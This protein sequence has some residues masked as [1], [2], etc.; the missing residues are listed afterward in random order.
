[1]EATHIKPRPIEAAGVG[2]P[3]TQSLSDEFGWRDLEKKVA[4]VFHQLPPQDQARAAILAANYGEAAALDVFGGEDGL[5]PALSGQNQYWLWGPRGH[6]GSLIIHVG[7][8][9]ERWRRICG[10]IEPAGRFGNPYA[11]PYENDRAIFICRD[12]RMPLDRLWDRLKR[13][14]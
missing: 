6:D 10:S 14:R 2:A 1:M 11:M 5:P 4:A 13:F 12:L 8:D 3:L 9:A 7:G